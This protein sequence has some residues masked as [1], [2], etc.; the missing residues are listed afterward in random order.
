MRW[1]SEV[2]PWSSSKLFHESFGSINIFSYQ[3]SRERCEVSSER[4]FTRALAAAGTTTPELGYETADGDV[5]DMAWAAGQVAVVFDQDEPVNGWT[6][7]PPDVN[8]IV[9]ALKTNGVV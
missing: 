7:C 1:C 6:L 3:R 2:V 8:K 5:L 4:T 9:E